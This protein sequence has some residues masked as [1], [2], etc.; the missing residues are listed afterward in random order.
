MHTLRTLANLF[1]RSAVGDQCASLIPEIEPIPLR[2]PWSFGIALGLYS[3][4]G[5]D[6]ERSQ[7]GEFLAAFKYSGHRHLARPLG[8]ALADAVR[9]HHPQIVVH[10]PSSRRNSLPGNAGVLPALFG[11][12]FEPACE[13]ARATAKALRAHC[14]PHLFA[15]TRTV[16]P[17]KELAS[18]SEKKANIAGAFKVRREELLRNR[19]AL[20]IDDVY[21]SGA[22]LEEAWRIVREAGASDIIVATV[23]K[24]RWGDGL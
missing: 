4:D 18:L 3:Q 1:S 13:L 12:A 11:C 22:T 15:F 20:I 9:A 5:E 7:I 14:L 16:P 2:G 17:Q 24:I 23:A 19:R 8:E 21:D 6:T 10:I